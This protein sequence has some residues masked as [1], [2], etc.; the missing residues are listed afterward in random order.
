MTWPPPF[1]SWIVDPIIP[2]GVADVLRVISMLGAL[3]LIVA[4]CYAVRISSYSDQRV[5]FGI[6]ALFAVM[7]TAGHLGSLAQPAPW[8][9]A[10]LPLVVAA[11]IWSTIKYVRRELGER[12]HGR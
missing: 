3:V 5:R 11:A 4:A 10:V 1:P 12:R 9:L 6:F 8:R 7:L 2:A